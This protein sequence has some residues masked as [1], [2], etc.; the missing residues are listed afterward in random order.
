MPYG[1]H[2]LVVRVRCGGRGFQG[3][4]V[5]DLAYQK[6]PKPRENG[7]SAV[8]KQVSK[9]AVKDSTNAGRRQ[10]RCQIPL[11]ETIWNNVVESV[12]LNACVNARKK[13]KKPETL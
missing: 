2:L 13:Q 8:Q 4:V 1:R 3:N 5:L 12:R 7:R 6:R 11:M 10:D 9:A